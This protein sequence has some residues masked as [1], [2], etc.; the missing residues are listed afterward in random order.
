MGC[1]MSRWP[2]SLSLLL[3]FF[4]FLSSHSEGF[5]SHQ[6]NL[7]ESKVRDESFILLLRYGP[8]LNSPN[9]CSFFLLFS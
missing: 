3:S 6:P 4:L 2:G 7:S 8:F 5:A 9:A 1:S